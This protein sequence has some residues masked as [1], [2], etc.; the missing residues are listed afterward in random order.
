[1]KDEKWIRD[2]RLELVEEVKEKRLFLQEEYGPNPE[3]LVSTHAQQYWDTR[4]EIDA[5]DGEIALLGEILEIEEEEGDE[6]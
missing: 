6:P 3:T 1:M 2:K 5:L 4:V